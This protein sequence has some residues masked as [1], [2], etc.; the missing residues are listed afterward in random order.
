MSHPLQP[1]ILFSSPLD[2]QTSCKK[3]N[4]LTF[5]LRLLS[6]CSGIEPIYQCRRCK[7]YR[8]D[9]WVGKIPW[10]RNWQPAPVFLP[11]KS[12]GQR[13]LAGCSPWGLKGSDMTECVCAYAHTHTL[14]HH[15]TFHS[16]FNTVP[17]ASHW[18]SPHQ[19]L[20]LVPGSRM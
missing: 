17:S 15:F 1:L 18:D 11:G 9:P 16:L 7:R 5:H 19:G 3:L 12:H 4:S 8:F 20:H 10:C 2:N 6:H 14:S 13:S